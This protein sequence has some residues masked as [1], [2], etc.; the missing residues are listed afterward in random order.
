MSNLITGLPLLWVTLYRGTLHRQFFGATW[1]LV[2][3]PGFR[4]S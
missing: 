3:Y 4:P 1:Y 2:A